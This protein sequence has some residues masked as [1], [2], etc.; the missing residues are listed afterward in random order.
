MNKVILMPVD[1]L[2]MDLSDKAIAWADR[3]LDKEE[4][5]LHLL[6]VFPK[7][8]TSAIRG[9]ASDIKKYEEYMANDAREK[10]LAL[11]RKFKTPLERIHF[12]VRYGNIRDEVNSAVAA[13]NADAIIIGSRKPGISTH[14]LGSAAANIL[15]YSKI[16]VLVVR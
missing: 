3:L 1:I 4:G 15:R 14:L 9:F 10:L 11:A 6:H 7:L 5:V 13:L 8:H 12:E 16:P 2:A